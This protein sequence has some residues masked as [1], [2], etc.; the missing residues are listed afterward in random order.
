LGASAVELARIVPA[1][2]ERLSIAPRPSNHPEEDRWR[3]LQSATDLLRNAAV[4]QPLLVVLEDLHD[5]DHGTLELLLYL[6]RNLHGAR[7]LLVGTYRDVAV[8]RC[9]PLAAALTELH[10]ASNVGLG[11]SVA[12]PQ[13][14]T[15]A[16][17]AAQYAQP[18]S[19]ERS[20]SELALGFARHA[21]GQ[22]A[23][24]RALRLDALAL[25][26]QHADPEALFSAAYP[27]LFIRGPTALGRTRAPCRGVCWLAAPGG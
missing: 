21:R 13:Y 17:R 7:L 26:R 16:E 10:R 2:Q 6:G 3:L 1:L 15:W 22:F 11:F 18:D 27:L 23:E 8:D 12:Q 14:L 20:F 9:H 19:I 5:A 24:A 25:A 4:K